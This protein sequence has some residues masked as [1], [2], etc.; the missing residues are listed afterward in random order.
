M[1]PTGRIGLMTPATVHH[2]RA[3]E[4]HAQRAHVLDAAYARTPERFVRRAPTRGEVLG[5]LG[6]ALERDRLAML[7]R[8][9]EHLRGTHH[10]LHGRDASPFAAHGEF[11]VKPLEKAH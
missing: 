9:D 6:L 8:S 1:F 7:K 2:G 5:L 10:H 11:P 3:P 4:A